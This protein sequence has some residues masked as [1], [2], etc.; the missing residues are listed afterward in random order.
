LKLELWFLVE[1]IHFHI[2]LNLKTY[3]P[4]PQNKLLLPTVFISRCTSDMLMK[5][6]K[7]LV[8]PW[9][10]IFCRIFHVS[11]AFVIFLLVL[12]I[13]IAMVWKLL[14]VLMEYH[15]RQYPQCFRSSIF[16]MPRYGIT[17]YDYYYLFLYQIFSANGVTVS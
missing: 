14:S 15:C 10:L 6:C 11:T 5:L 13:I 12:E 8:S 4:P 1:V 9:I 3:P 7:C 17:N 16:S 2:I